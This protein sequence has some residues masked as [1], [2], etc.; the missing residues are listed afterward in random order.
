MDKNTSE[1]E[2]VY[3]SLTGEIVLNPS[4]LPEKLRGWRRYRIEYGG[5]AECC[6]KELPIYLPMCADAYLIDLL[7]EFWQA[8]TVFEMAIK[9]A[10][11][12]RELKAAIKR[13]HSNPYVQEDRST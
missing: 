11:I 12:A 6:V 9:A 4:A 2:Q 5:H 7:F 3:V 1:Y 10:D 13:K 8:D